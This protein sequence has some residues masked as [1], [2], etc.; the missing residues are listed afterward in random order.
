MKEAF[1]LLCATPGLLEPILGV[2]DFSALSCVCRDFQT[3]FKN[4]ICEILAWSV[5]K[6]MKDNMWNNPH[7][8][9]LIVQ[10]PFPGHQSLPPGLTTLY[11]PGPPKK[12]RK[13]ILPKNLT[14]L[15]THLLGWMQEI[16]NFIHD[17][18]TCL[19]LFDK[20]QFP[21]VCKMGNNLQRLLLPDTYDGSAINL[22]N[23]TKLEF[24][25]L[26]GGQSGPWELELPQSVTH[27]KTGDRF[28]LP[29]HQLNLSKNVTTLELGS[30]FNQ[31]IKEGD[32]PDTLS[33]LILGAYFNQDLP[34]LPRGLKELHMKEQY[35]VLHYRYV[36]RNIVATDASISFT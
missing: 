36:Q 12:R 26:G 13:F 33:V 22:A 11:M 17:E 23:C 24:V 31:E 3:P 6:V 15:A 4:Y 34:W 2:D 19:N 18:I 1:G 25:Q 35:A 16:P 14:L 5:S 32:I 10:K 20:T 27:V 29:L 21:L 7:I 30:D 9:S 28:N 8:R